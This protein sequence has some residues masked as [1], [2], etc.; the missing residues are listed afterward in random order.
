[1]INI[2]IANNHLTIDE[3]IFYT[4]EKDINSITFSFNFETIK[5]NINDIKYIF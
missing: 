1:M 4:F 5:N 2:H 3:T